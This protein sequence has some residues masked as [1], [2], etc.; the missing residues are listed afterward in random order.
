MMLWCTEVY[1][2]R[3]VPWFLDESVEKL[4]GASGQSYLGARLGLSFKGLTV[5]GTPNFSTLPDGALQ[6][7]AYP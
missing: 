3:G 2:G 1:E 7:V 4:G 5:A 6:R